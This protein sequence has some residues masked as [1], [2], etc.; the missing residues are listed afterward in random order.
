M[1]IRCLKNWARRSVPQNGQIRNQISLRTRIDG[2]GKERKIYMKIKAGTR[3]KL[4]ALCLIVILVIC[5]MT[6][7][8]SPFSN[9]EKKKDPLSISGFAFDTTYTIT[10]YAGGSRNVLD[11]C[12]SLCTKYEKLFSTTRKDSELYQINRVSREAAQSGEIDGSVSLKISKDMQDIL[13]KGLYY[14]RLSK[15]RFDITIDPVSSLWDFSSGKGTVPEAAEIEKALNYV[16][17]KKVT[18]K[19]NRLTLKK[20]GMELD[21]GGIAKGYIA[22]RLKEYLSQNGVTSAVID[23]GGNILCLGGKSENGDFRIGIQQPFADHSETVS[24]V[25]IRDKSV[26]SSGIYERYIKAEDGTL[27]HHIL[28]PKTGYSYENDLLGVSIISDKSVDGDGLSTT[29]FALGLSDGMKMI[30]SMDGVEALFITK[31]EKLHYSSGFKSYM[32]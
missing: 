18:L 17:Y 24:V 5:S 2:Q 16:D 4:P 26:V 11:Q 29:A 23:L 20:S 9:T 28:D 13:Q 25:N 19:K 31:D 8:V 15:G 32:D 30:N 10:I 14:S 7:C 6:G 27:Y 12:I 1:R 22:D 21:L 3:K